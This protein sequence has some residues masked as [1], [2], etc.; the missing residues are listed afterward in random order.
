M[1]LP[2]DLHF[3]RLPYQTLLPVIN[4]WNL[5]FLRLVKMVG[6]E[7]LFAK[8]NPAPPPAAGQLHATRGSLPVQGEDRPAVAHVFQGCGVIEGRKDEARRHGSE[9]LL[10]R[11][12]QQ[13]TVLLDHS[14]APGN[15]LVA[16]R[17]G[18]VN[19]QRGMP[20]ISLKSRAH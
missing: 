18:P 14:N 5:S 9:G 17:F 7:R 16:S 1:P 13:V 10:G 20:A 8:R 12:C 3:F 6:Q 4:R 19:S 11:P 15:R 2:S